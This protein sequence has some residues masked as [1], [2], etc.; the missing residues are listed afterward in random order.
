[1]NAM[2]IRQVSTTA[3]AMKV[4]V[5]IVRRETNREAGSLTNDSMV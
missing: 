3:A 4:F 5:R 1:M 2:A